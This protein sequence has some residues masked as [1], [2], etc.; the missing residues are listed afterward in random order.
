MI[1]VL[2][3]DDAVRD[4]FDAG[5]LH[6]YDK[7]LLL[8][9]HDRDVQFPRYFRK[10]RKK[11][12][13]GLAFFCYNSINCKKFLAVFCIRRACIWIEL[14]HARSFRFTNIIAQ[15]TGAVFSM[16]NVCRG[17]YLSSSWGYTGG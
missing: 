17:I 1:F 11:T 3:A 6:N 10:I 2:E 8:F 13:A 15:V 9:A 7:E 4:T 5:R 14:K 12:I 16:K